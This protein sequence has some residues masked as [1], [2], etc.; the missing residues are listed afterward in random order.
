MNRSPLFYPMNR[1]TDADAG[2]AADLQTDVMRFMAI[3]SLCL[4][5]IF[6]LV[7]SIPLAATP[8][9]DTASDAKIPPEARQ[10]VVMADDGHTKRS[11]IALAD[12]AG[13]KLVRPSSQMPSPP[14]EVALQRPAPVKPRPIGG[15]LTKPSSPMTVADSAAA[16]PAV[17]EQGFSLHFA[18]DQVLTHLVETQIVGLYV[19]TEDS[20]LR[21]S[22]RRGDLNFWPASIPGEFHEMD[23]STVPEQIIAAY[24]DAQKRR[25]RWGV[26]LPAKMSEELNDYLAN[27]N[28][29]RLTITGDGRIELL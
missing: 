26:T 23:E 27:A 8:Q 29:G 21:L 22:V 1:G 18:T 10:A 12:V 9:Q 19:M 20:A 25:T 6:A 2:G 13:A 7:Q 3:L 4:V 5:A 28:G 16:S 15:A 11:G 17:G 24:P 14:V